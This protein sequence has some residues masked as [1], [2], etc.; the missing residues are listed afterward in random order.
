METT[1]INTTDPEKLDAYLSSSDGQK[2]VK[3]VI[4]AAATRTKAQDIFESMIK[5]YFAGPR[6]KEMMKQLVLNSISECASSVR[7]ILR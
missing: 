4:Q 3:R 1:I 7:R 2:A 5:E 6:G